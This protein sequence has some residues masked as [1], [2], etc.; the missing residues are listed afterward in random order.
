[1]TKRRKRNDGGKGAGQSLQREGGKEM[2]D[3]MKCVS[4]NYSKLFSMNS[5]ELFSMNT[6]LRGQY[7]VKRNIIIF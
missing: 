7:C 1:M 4:P 2:G 6:T 5:Q 3:F